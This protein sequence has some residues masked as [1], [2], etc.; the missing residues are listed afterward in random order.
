M[1]S[2]LIII[3]GTLRGSKGSHFSWNG[4]QLNIILRRASILHLVYWRHLRYDF[5]EAMNEHIFLLSHV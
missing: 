3:E 4:L 2:T 1:I 5:I